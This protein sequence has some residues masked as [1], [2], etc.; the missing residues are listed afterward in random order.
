MDILIKQQTAAKTI[1]ARGLL[2]VVLC[3]SAWLLLL[4]GMREQGGQ[5]W[6]IVA[7]LALFHGH[8]TLCWLRSRNWV[9]ALSEADGETALTVT[10]VK[11]QLVTHKS[12]KYGPRHLEAIYLITDGKER[13]LYILPE[14]VVHNGSVRQTVNNACVGGAVSI[15]CYSGTNMVKAIAHLTTED[16]TLK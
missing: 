8:H 9:K 6:I 3:F 16:M 13:F 5:F 12:S 10:C 4:V 7:I 2:R 11:T 1:Q 14:P 15:V